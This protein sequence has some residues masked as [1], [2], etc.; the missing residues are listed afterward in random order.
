MYSGFIEQS[1]TVVMT[2]ISQHHQN[3]IDTRNLN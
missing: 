1:C 2:T 3:D